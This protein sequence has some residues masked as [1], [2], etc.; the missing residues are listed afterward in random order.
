MKKNIFQYPLSFF[1]IILLPILPPPFP[2]LLRWWWRT[3][4]PTTPLTSTTTVD[5]VIP[6]MT[7][8]RGGMDHNNR[9]C[10]EM[11]AENAPSRYPPHSISDGGYATVGATSPPHYHRHNTTAYKIIIKCYTVD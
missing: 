2:F 7:T 3:P 9:S 4:L 1:L 6:S 11:V 8:V 10:S 5:D